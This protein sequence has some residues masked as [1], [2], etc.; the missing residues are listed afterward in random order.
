M[1]GAGCLEAS[2]SGI[3]LPGSLQDASRSA[4]S[5]LFVL[6]PTGS[7]RWNPLSP[8]CSAGGEQGG[9]LHG[10]WGHSLF[11]QEA[12]M[13]TLSRVELSAS[14]GLG[15]RAPRPLVLAAQG[16]SSSPAPRSLHPPSLPESFSLPSITTISVDLES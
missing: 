5:R 6:G 1:D 14:P 12:S 13:Q 3:C 8:A 4:S 15:H 2:V 10:G 9:C 16:L 11:G 7:Q